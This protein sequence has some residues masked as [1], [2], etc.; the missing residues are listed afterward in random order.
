MSEVTLSL[1]FPSSL[2]LLIYSL[3]FYPSFLYPF[4]LSLLSRLDRTR[5][6][7]RLELRTSKR[8][9]LVDPVGPYRARIPSPLSPFPSDIHGAREQANPSIPCLFFLLFFFHSSLHHSFLQHFLFYFPRP[10]D[11]VII[12]PGFV[13]DWSPFA[14]LHSPPSTSV[15]QQHTCRRARRIDSAPVYLPVF[16][17]SSPTST[18][19]SDM[20]IAGSAAVHPV[21]HSLTRS[22]RMAPA[23]PAL[24]SSPAVG[25]CIHRLVDKSL[26]P[27]KTVAHHLLRL[28]HPS[29]TGPIGLSFLYFSFF[30][31]PSIFFHSF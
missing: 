23:P 13:P 24:S 21:S 17:P 28:H 30:L 3:F 14:C 12:R 9:R 7:D 4:V 5:C 25:I 1:F 31:F 26:F 8:P 22:F 18:T 15:F 20:H 16:R 29:G 11:D 27:R 10:G 6:D 19:L 2:P